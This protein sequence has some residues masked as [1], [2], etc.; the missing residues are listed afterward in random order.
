[1]SESV[2]GIIL[3][4]GH[5][6]RLGGVNKAMLEIGGRTN[7]ARVSLALN[8]LCS[9]LIAVTND[10]SL[11]SIR[12]LRV[13]RD[14]QPHAGVLPALLQGLRGRQLRSGNRGRL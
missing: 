12:Y 3:A 9:E 4:G 8:E 5:G 13:L 6:S 11:D 7:L 2:S 1:M 10:D 14:E